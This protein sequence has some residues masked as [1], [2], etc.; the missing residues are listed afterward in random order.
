MNDYDY[1]S[2]NDYHLYHQMLISKHT[3]F[4]Y[5]LVIKAL[6]PINKCTF[7]FAVDLKEEAK[8]MCVFEMIN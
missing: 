5:I 4:A 8:K 6:V 1:K 3:I 7:L 2:K